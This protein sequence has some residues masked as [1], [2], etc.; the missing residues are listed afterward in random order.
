MGKERAKE[1]IESAE[2]NMY[3]YKAV[4]DINM[5]QM[6]IKAEAREYHSLRRQLQ[7]G[8][9]SVYTGSRGVE[10]K[11]FCLDNPDL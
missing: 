1:I 11:C 5:W 7:S 3:K 4:H 10:E 2:N 9:F 6:Y 8:L